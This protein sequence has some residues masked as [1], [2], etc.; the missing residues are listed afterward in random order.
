MTIKGTT[1]E[2]KLIVEHLNGVILE[3]KPMYV[4]YKK[5]PKKKIDTKIQPS[6]E[7]DTAEPPK[8]QRLIQDF[9]PRGTPSSREEKKYQEPYYGETERKA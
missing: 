5:V 1:A 7:A 4:S 3:G 8:K 9:A 6:K 2:V